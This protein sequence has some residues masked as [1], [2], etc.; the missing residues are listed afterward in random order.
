MSNTRAGFIELRLVP[1]GKYPLTSTT[2]C[3]AF[4]T[5][6]HTLPPVP[7]LAITAFGITAPVVKFKFDAVGWADPHG[8]TVT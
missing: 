3:V 7:I 4:D 1:N 8:K 2:R 5:N 6:K